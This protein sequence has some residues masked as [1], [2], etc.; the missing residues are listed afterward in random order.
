MV[1]QSSPAADAPSSALASAEADIT[2]IDMDD[3]RAHDAA[4]L[5]FL[6]SVR[7]LAHLESAIR[8]LRRTPAVMDV[9][10]VRPRA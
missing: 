2:H 9:Q 6:L 5:R 8:I 7:D 4:D 10:R 1:L 3:D